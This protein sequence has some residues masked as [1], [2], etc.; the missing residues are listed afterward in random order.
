MFSRKKI[1][2]YSLCFAV[3]FLFS[4]CN[5]KQAD[6]VFSQLN[7]LVKDKQFFKLETQ[8]QKRKDQLDRPQQLYFRAFINNAF[9]RN[10]MAAK[11][12]DSL[13]Q[14]YPKSFSDSAKA[15]LLQIRE[16]SYFKLFQYAKAAKTDSIL[17]H[18]YK[19]V[20]DSSDLEDRK[21]KFLLTNA[22]R[23]THPQRIEKNNVADIKW[24]RNVLGL[25][26]IPLRHDTS[27][28]TAIFD[29]RA[30]IS[31]ITQTFAKKLKLKMLPVSYEEGSGITGIKFKT[32]LGVADSLYIGDILIR[33]AV[34]QVMPDS[35]LYLK[36]LNFSLDLIIGFPVIAS[37]GE[38]HI[39]KD[40][41][42]IIP[43]YETESG[44]HNLALD[45]LDPVVLLKTGHDTLPFNLDLGA[46]TTDL[47]YAFYQKYKSRIMKEGH[48][49]EMHVAGAGGIQNKTVY[50][51]PSLSLTLDNKTITIDSVDIFTK[52][53]FPGEKLYGN[54]GNDFASQFTDL[55]LNF[56]KMYI[57]GK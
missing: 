43:Q 49:K 36:P 33:N 41:Q 52:K 16:D 55:V 5:Q 47:Y 11:Q 4:Q 29:T 45:E 54:I 7:S 24:E 22:L 42:M 25:I 46:G 18:D 3:I 20:L 13:L 2:Y 53:I 28:F 40:G 37:L 51:L 6:K 14:Q 1:V 30:N 50:I 9:N 35:I 21:N 12:V 38:I 48:Q 26:T 31:S 34:F 56:D 39:L 15:L 32:G 10:V 19:E 44:L 57:S 17:I 23:T 8:F 27:T